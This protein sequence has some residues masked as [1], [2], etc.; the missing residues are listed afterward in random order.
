MPLKFT[1]A[2]VRALPA[3]KTGS[4]EITSDKS[5]K[6]F[7][8]RVTRAGARSFLLNY[9]TKLG[10][11]RQ[12]TIGAFPDWKA[13]AARIEAAEL[14]KQIDRGGDP[15]GD[16]QAGREAPTVADL[17]DRFVADYLPRKRPSTA[18]SYRQQIE[19]DIRPALGKLKV[20]AVTFADVDG[21]HRA[22]SRGRAPSREIVASPCSRRCS[23]CRSAGTCGPTIRAGA[24]SATLS[25]SGGAICRLRSLVA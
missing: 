5:V 18:Y 20:A 16:I 4:G 8:V 17:C 15:L 3:P 7:G 21:L 11:E 2:I 13:G 24:S 22:I 12:F 19:V 10:R 23:A 14:K 25:I 6:G 1:D 9:R